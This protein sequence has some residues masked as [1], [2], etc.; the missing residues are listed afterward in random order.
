[1]RDILKNVDQWIK[2][3][4][5][6]ALATVIHT[7][8]SA[9][10]RVGAK[11]AF[12]QSG[13][14]SGSVSGG[15]VESAVFEAGLQSLR[16]GQSQLLKFGVADET[17][18]Q[19][20][21]ACGGRIEVFVQALDPVFFDLSKARLLSNQ[22][23]C[24]ASV[25][26]GPD[27]LPGKAMLVSQDSV[28]LSL[29]SGLDEVCIEKSRLVLAQGRSQTVELD[30]KAGLVRVFIEVV[31]PT[32]TLIM[33]GGV[34]IA[35]ALTALAKTLGFRTLVIDPRRAFGNAA[36]FPDVDRLIQSWPEQAFSQVDISSGDAVVM[37]THDPKIDDPALKKV[38]NSPAFYIGALGSRATHE[39]RR[40]RLLA[41]GVSSAQMERLHAPIGLDI[42]AES[43]EEIALAIMAE[44]VA[45]QHQSNRASVLVRADQ[46]PG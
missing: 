17:A 28:Q 15:C 31:K 40:R 10:R 41:D 12:T 6:V 3:G 29:G 21:L 36:R 11:M 1:M 5:S 9:P 14:I 24:V 2:N 33:V 46:Q 22:A 27:D 37:L 8:G 23:F 42:G 20:G 25:I 45:A 16:D 19:V 7:W 18:W 4:E 32:P 34:H 38:L 13:E 35:I 44:I 43:P 26:E 30:S 39:K